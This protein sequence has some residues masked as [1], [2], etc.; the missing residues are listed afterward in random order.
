LIQIK[1]PGATT[2]TLIKK[3]GKFAKLDP[4]AA[5]VFLIRSWNSGTGG[6][7]LVCRFGLR[8]AR[9]G[10]Y[11]AIIQGS[12]IKVFFEEKFFVEITKRQGGPFQC[13]VERNCQ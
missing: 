13:L 6:I 5:A 9:E 10:W 3:D 2:P 7:E 1:A 4:V 11:H 8:I 12:R